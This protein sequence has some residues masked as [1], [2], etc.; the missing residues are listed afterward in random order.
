MV[1][2]TNVYFEIIFLFYTNSGTVVSYAFK[3][4]VI[5]NKK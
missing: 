2:S 3:Q 1:D 4:L 5:Y